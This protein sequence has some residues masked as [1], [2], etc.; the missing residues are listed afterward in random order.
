MLAIERCNNVGGI[1]LIKNEILVGVMMCFV[2]LTGTV[3]AAQNATVIMTFDDG[4]YSILQNATPIMDANGQ[5]G[6]EFI[7]TQEPDFP[8]SGQPG[9]YMSVPQLQQLYG[10]GWDLGS[11]TVSHVN[12]T[13]VNDTTLNYE[14]RTSQD[15]L[16]NNN[17]PRGS[18]FFAYPEGAYNSAVITALQANHYV[19]ARTIIPPDSNYSQYTLASP[20]I[21]MLKD[22][23]VVGSIDNATTIENQINNTIAVNG[24]LILSFHKIVGTLSTNV[25]DI[26]T[27]FPISDFQSVSNYLKTLSDNG[28]VT[29][30]T[31]SGY[32][33]A[34]PLPRYIPP[35]PTGLS[36]AIYLNLT[37]SRMNVSWTPGIGDN[38][39]L[40]NIFVN[41][42][43]VNDTVSPFININVFPGELI[44]MSVYAVNTTNGNTLNPVPA[45]LNITIPLLQTY[46]PP[47]PVNLT[48]VNGGNDRWILA[49]WGSGSGNTTDLFNV[50]VD[51][52]S[53]NGTLWINGTTNTSYNI[54]GAVPGI[55]YQ[56]KI[57]AVNVTNG[58]TMN[59]IPAIIDG[60]IPLYTPSIPIEVGQ[61]SGNFW[62]LF[63]WNNVTGNATNNVTGNITDLYNVSVSG[64]SINGTLHINLTTN[65]SI[66]VTSIPHGYVQ[67]SVYSYNSTNGGVQN[68]I[69]LFMSMQMPNNLI[70]FGN[71][72]AEY[73][74]YAG[75]TLRIIPT[76][77]NPDNDTVRF[78]TNATNASINSTTGE[79]I[80][81]TSIGE[82]GPYHW[83][84]TAYDDQGTPRIMDFIVVITPKPTYNGGGGGNGGGNNGGGGGGGDVNTYDPNAASYERRDSQIRHNASSTVEFSKNGL[85]D[86]VTFYGIRNYGDV[87]V[88]VSILKDD[89]T[90]SYLGNVYK[91]FAVK[92]DN[93]PQKNE[94]LYISNS[95]VVVSVD[96]SN[97]SDNTIKVY[98]YVNDSWVP[99]DIEDTNIENP[100]TK[101]FK[102]KSDGLSNF[103]IVLEQKKPIEL[104]I[105]GGKNSASYDNASITGNKVIDK[106][107]KNVVPESFYR[108]VI[109][110]IK[111]YMPWV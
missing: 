99:V 27:E 93:I 7:I 101:Q 95:T 79:F 80:Y 82:K 33:G 56:V 45:Y 3:T 100:L 32:F 86:N 85:V 9:G 64:S 4:W 94:Y 54:T 35:T 19:G 41:G 87:T 28:N 16:Y 98:R 103:A 30:T 73:D 1:K 17:F 22:Y 108:Y 39:D 61:S 83:N 105:L 14:L 43:R 92:L 49:G 88:K 25:T 2:V 59:Q 72:W 50:S 89:P 53:I 62:A 75:D 24:L 55:V 76:V 57:Y 110:L 13:T 40:Y 67:V 47:T 37:A 20:D 21:F 18:I 23:E 31:L 52:L 65:K 48:A 34:V 71:I 66:N 26:D 90:P 69:P 6:V 81:N 77:Y 29:V 68:P 11:H 51:S 10:K 8:W 58:T 46:I 106:A 36:A 63:E 60:I 91:F 70:D 111:K 12:L 42:V 74:V 109:N 84:I 38:T 102:L 5:R 15:W 97:L 78:T 44:N 96:K 107:I 104:A